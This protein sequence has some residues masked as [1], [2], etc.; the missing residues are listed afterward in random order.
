MPEIDP[1]PGP[2][3]DPDHGHGSVPGQPGGGVAERDPRQARVDPLRTLWADAALAERRRILVVEVEIRE[4][5]FPPLGGIGG[6]LD[7]PD[8]HEVVHFRLLC[9]AAPFD[10]RR[11]HQDGSGGW[12]WDGVQRYYAE[13][14]PEPEDPGEV[15]WA[16]YHVVPDAATGTAGYA[17]IDPGDTGVLGRARLVY[18]ESGG[19]SDAA[20]VSPAAVG[21]PAAAAGHGRR[22]VPPPDSDDIP[23]R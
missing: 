21:A 23:W 4:S 20:G 1:G 16:E 8:T 2:G 19:D 14:V 3:P 17:H 11:G 15:L 9:T 13:A 10:R 6:A 7:Y 12:T 5:G 22:A 18:E